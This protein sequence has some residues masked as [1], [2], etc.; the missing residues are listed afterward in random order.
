MTQRTLKNIL[1]AESAEMLIPGP[2]PQRFELNR[3]RM[4]PGNMCFNKLQDD[5]DAAGPL[6]VL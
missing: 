5:F 1:S 2:H 3:S 6:T 4:G